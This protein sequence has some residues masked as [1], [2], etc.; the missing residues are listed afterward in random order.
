MTDDALKRLAT[1]NSAELLD[2][3]ADL[4]DTVA[5]MPTSAMKLF[6]AYC[7]LTGIGDIIDDVAP[8][9]RVFFERHIPKLRSAD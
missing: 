4:R 9:A 8:E 6:M 7:V 3:I 2:G 5:N 1:D